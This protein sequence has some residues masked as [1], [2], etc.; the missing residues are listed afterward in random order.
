[1]EQRK[2]CS[3]GNTHQTKLLT[4]KKKRPEVLRAPEK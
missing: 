4:H 3:Q 2:D 1:M